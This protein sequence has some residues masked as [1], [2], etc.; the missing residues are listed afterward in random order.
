MQKQGTLKGIVDKIVYRSDE[1]G[2]TVLRLSVNSRE[3]VTVTGHLPDLQAGEQVLLDGSWGFHQKFG[4]QFVAEKATSQ[5]PSSALGIKKYLGSGLIK[6]IGPKFAERLVDR[7]K[8]QTLEVIDK[9][10]NRLFEVSGVGARRVQLITDAWQEQKEISRVM[11]FLHEHEI[12]SAF[13]VKIYKTY[14]EQSIALVQEDPYR[15]VEDVWGI[16][17]KTADKLAIKLGL[18]PG[19]LKRVRAGLLHVIAQIVDK[20]H[21]YIEVPELKQNAIEL[22]QL[23][24]ALVRFALK[25]LY[26]QNK[27]KL[28]STNDKHYVSLPQYYFSEKGIANK[29]KNLQHYAGLRARFSISIDEVYKKIRLPNKVGIALNND[30]QHGII[31]CLQHKVSVITGGPGTG[32]T[33]LVRTLLDV[34]DGHKVKYRLAA[35]TGRAAK[36]MFEGTGRNTE[37][38]H[39]L[40]E[41]TP[42]AMNF[43]RNEQ[44]ALELDFLIVD[45]ASMIDVFLM[46][47]ILRALPH[48][49]HLLLLG[50]VDQ[51]PSVG[52]GNVLNDIIASERVMVVR[53]NEIFR[54]AQ[55]SLIVLNAHRVN[56]GEFPSTS[57]PATRNDFVFIKE[58]EP[59]NV[60]GLLRDIYTRQLPVHGILPS[61]SIVLTPMNR[62]IVGTQRLNQ[63]LQL[64]LNPGESNRQVSRFGQVYKIGDRVMQIRNN[65]TKFVFNGDIGV[66]TD[67]N[68]IDQVLRINFG[69][70]E[71]EYD[72]AELDEIVLSY[73]VSIHKSQGSEFSAVIVPI[74]MQHFI[75]L[76]RNLIYTAITRAKKLCVLIGQSKAIYIGIKNAKGVERKTFLRE[77]MTSDLAAR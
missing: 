65:Y 30:Q 43:T 40:L 53:L 63:E 58:Q 17:F 24:S 44:N 45:E 26:N 14:G 49:A 28:V 64:I 47:A 18:E 61:D 6:G 11:V 77:Y 21:L 22:L 59:E 57:L 3:V 55:G 35:P 8:E 76:Q 9:E 41:F 66:I 25:D 48:H 46:H 7:F 39:R 36:R 15:L 20:G 12:S 27:I 54:Q 37:T 13:A 5:L 73:A 71:L 4:R 1:N 29:I 52:A 51:L 32:K 10:P 70:R 19:S 31:S 34:L 2:F 69:D 16:G 68:M 33:T 56:N 75:L 38:L 74:F 23:N 42:S 60:F 72:F 62:G 50:D 67:I